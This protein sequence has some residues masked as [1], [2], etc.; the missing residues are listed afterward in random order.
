MMHMSLDLGPVENLGVA[1]MTM[2][3][4]IAD[5][6]TRI[7]NATLVRHRAVVMP[8]SRIKEAIAHALKDEGYITRYEVLRDT[9]FPVL[10]ITLK[11][12]GERES[13]LSEIKRVSKPGCRVY[14]RAKDIPWVKSGLGIVV[15][16]T[17][18]GVMSGQEARRHNVGGEILC[19]AW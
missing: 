14:T 16:S 13:V 4:P 8:S 18:L 3:D 19:E 10:R 12:V 15:L 9:R 6:L 11:Y 17:P 1:Q 2:T 5:M 7:R